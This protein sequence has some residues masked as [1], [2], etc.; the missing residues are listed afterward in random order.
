MRD[1]LLYR[2]NHHCCGLLSSDGEA[3]FKFRIG[4]DP[5]ASVYAVGFVRSRHEEDERDTGVFNKILETVNLIVAQTIGY[6]QRPA[7]VRNPYKA[8]PIA[9]RRAIETFFASSCENQE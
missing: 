6:V 5:R 2:N 3:S 4:A 1:H 8:R 9:L 7:V